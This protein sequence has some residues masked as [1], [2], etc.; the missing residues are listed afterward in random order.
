MGHSWTVT[1][2]YSSVL[3][4]SSVTVLRLTG[5]P[6]SL[7]IE[8]AELLRMVSLSLTAVVDRVI[9]AWHRLVR[10]LECSVLLAVLM[11]LHRWPVG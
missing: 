5:R 7:V 4:Q 9:M 10:S 11:V 6:G 3:G 8:S 2:R 1:A